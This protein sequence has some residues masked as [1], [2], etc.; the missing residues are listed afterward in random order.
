MQE[1]SYI[2]ACAAI[3]TQFVVDEMSGVNHG[4]QMEMDGTH[5]DP[6]SKRGEIKHRH[7][8]NGRHAGGEMCQYLHLCSGSAGPAYCTVIDILYY[9]CAHC[10][11]CLMTSTSWTAVLFWQQKISSSIKPNHDAKSVS[12][13]SCMTVCEYV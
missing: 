10:R 8:K 12:S 13:L 7:I 4:T 3:R 11:E 9:V 2:F 1:T 5:D 6:R